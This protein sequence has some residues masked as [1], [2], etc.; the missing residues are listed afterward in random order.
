[1]I[2]AWPSIMK[3][4]RVFA[5]E[6]LL[7]L[8]MMQFS[9]SSSSIFVEV[10]DL[11]TVAMDAPAS[12]L[13]L[14]KRKERKQ[15]Y[16]N[17][18]STMSMSST[19]LSKKE[20]SNI[21]WLCYLCEQDKLEHYGSLGRS[22]TASAPGTARQ[23]SA[24][25]TPGT[26]GMQ[27]EELSITIPYSESV[28]TGEYCCLPMTVTAVE[29]QTMHPEEDI[30]SFISL[31][32]VINDPTKQWVPFGILPE[33]EIRRIIQCTVLVITSP[34]FSLT[35]IKRLCREAKNAPEVDYAWCILLII[36]SC[37]R[38][39]ALCLYAELAW[40]HRV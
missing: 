27:G 19:L 17:S 30:I 15:R 18:H 31:H 11:G 22:R 2:S 9:V 39:C 12:P 33:S 8:L 26:P 16:I 10:I 34:S 14:A 37:G 21:H 6:R 3:L 36:F 29:F 32:S 35:D 20:L 38:I 7:F 13:R 25:S 28:L 1:M 40:V 4:C 5:V 24:V 23:R